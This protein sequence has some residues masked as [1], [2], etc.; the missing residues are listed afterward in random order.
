MEEKASKLWG[1]TFLSRVLI[2]LVEPNCFFCCGSFL[3]FKIYMF[4]KSKSFFVSLF[5]FFKFYC[6]IS[7]NSSIGG[8]IGIMCPKEGKVGWYARESIISCKPPVT[9]ILAIKK[10]ISMS[11]KIYFS[12]NISPI[13]SILPCLKVSVKEPFSFVKEHCSAWHLFKK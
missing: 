5:F 1:R 6:F 8:R 4:Y 3:Y 11:V 10:N 7:S 2:Y 13:L 12:L 9:C